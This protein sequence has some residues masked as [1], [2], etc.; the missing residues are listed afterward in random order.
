[1]KIYT[2]RNGTMQNLDRGI[3]GRRVSV[4][5]VS[6]KSECYHDLNEVK[7]EKKREKDYSTVRKK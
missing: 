2:K 4:Y 7:G 5:D 6:Y 1:M 3:N